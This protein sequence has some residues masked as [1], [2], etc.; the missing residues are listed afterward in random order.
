MKCKK[1]CALFFGLLTA[2]SA[3]AMQSTKIIGITGT[4]LTVSFEGTR[5]QPT[6]AGSLGSPW[7]V[8]LNP[9]SINL[10][11]REQIVGGG[12]P[13]SAGCNV[14][15]SSSLYPLAAKVV[16]NFQKGALLKVTMQNGVCTSIS[17]QRISTDSE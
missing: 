3:S 13:R 8:Y 16:A 4:A 9:G 14:S 10:Q 6:A 12:Q 17:M 1:M 2:H 11:I 7:D 15:P 5:D